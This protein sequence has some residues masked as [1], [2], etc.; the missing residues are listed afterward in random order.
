MSLEVFKDE[1]LVFSSSS[2]WLYP[3]FGLEDF[4]AEHD[5]ISPSLLRVHDTVQ[6]RAAAVLTYRL[7]IKTVQ[8]DTMSSLAANFLKSKNISFSYS[9]LVPKILCAT[10]D[11][12]TDEMSVDQVYSLLCQRAGRTKDKTE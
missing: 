1:E 10:E 2:K 6:G 4:L 5:E 12:I 3:L 11:I 8:A 7:G 9:K